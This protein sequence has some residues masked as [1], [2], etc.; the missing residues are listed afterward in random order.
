MIRKR[1][2]S[3]IDGTLIPGVAA[4]SAPVFGPDGRMVLALTA[5]GHAGAF[6]TRWTGRIASALRRSGSEPIHAAWAPGNTQAS[7]KLRLD[8]NLTI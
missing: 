7:L 5:L 3:R 2:L 1:G 8:E 6:D 4:F